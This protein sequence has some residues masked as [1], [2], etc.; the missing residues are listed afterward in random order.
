MEDPTIPSVFA[1][2][3]VGDAGS[4]DDGGLD[5]G[6][7]A[8]ERSRER[9]RS[10]K[11]RQAGADGPASVAPVA[12]IRKEI[13][14]DGLSV[15][16]KESTSDWWRKKAIIGQEEEEEDGFLY[17]GDGDKSRQTRHELQP[18]PPRQRGASALPAADSPA[19]GPVPGTRSTTA[20]NAETAMKLSPNT[21]AVFILCPVNA[22]GNLVVDIQGAMG[23]TTATPSSSSNTGR[24]VTELGA[25]VA[26][27]APAGGKV[28]APAGRDRDGGEE[29]GG[30]NSSGT[31][32]APLAAVSLNIEKV[33]VQVDMRQY[34]ILNEVV[35]AA[36]MSQRRFRFRRERPTMAVFDDPEAWWRYA[37]K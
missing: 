20:D 23:N 30:D 34:A 9:S 19:S 4:H 8:R 32:P 22:R 6:G 1:H 15:Y 31:E 5:S 17:V 13:E 10:P 16:T 35:S 12:G 27:R 33:P 18:I 14:L 3:L 36:A 11:A 2:G 28:S 29:T 24:P 37:I 7:L 25:D 21:E 26:D